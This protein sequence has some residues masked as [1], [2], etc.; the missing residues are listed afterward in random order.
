MDRKFET[1]LIVAVIAL[2]AVVVGL[3]IY[4]FRLEGR[5]TSVV[6]KTSPSP[7]L[8]AKASLETCGIKKEGNPLV[9]DI[10]TLEDGTVVGNFF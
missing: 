5:K 7:T 9:K 1:I 10:Q 4:L 6:P 2:V 3:N 8:Q